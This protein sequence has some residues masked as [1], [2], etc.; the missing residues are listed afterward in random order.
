MTNEASQLVLVKQ[1]ADEADRMLGRKSAFGDGQAVSLM[2][3][4]VEL[5]IRAVAR[6]LNVEVQARATLD[7]MVDAIGKVASDEF[8]KIPHRARIED[9]NKARVGFKHSGTAPSSE[10]ARR[11]V[12]Y[13]V[14][15]LEVAVPRFFDVEYRRIS[16]AQSIR[17]A[18]IL[19][20][21]QRAEIAALE[22]RF[23]DAMVETSD[24]VGVVERSLSQVMPLPTT[25]IRAP[26]VDGQAIEH[27]LKYLIG[28]RNVSIAAMM[29]FDLRDLMKFRQT[30]P[31]VSGSGPTRR[32]AVFNGPMQYT[33]EQAESA[34]AFAISFALAVESRIG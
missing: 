26:G 9:L 29:Q 14:E 4:A 15:F 20:L 32:Q 19:A 1:F 6:N 30:A 27:L 12:R 17:S 24:A 18:E 31:R 7:Q 25:P 21:L 2:Q 34:I 33:A 10:D 23:N 11:L 5:L 28:L 22:G 13:G 3:D 16:L 8:G